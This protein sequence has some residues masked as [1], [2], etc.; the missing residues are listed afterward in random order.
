MTEGPR[1]RRPW[2]RSSPASVPQCWQ[3]ERVVLGRSKRCQ[4]AYAFRW[5]CSYIRLELA[6][7]GSAPLSPAY[8]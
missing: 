2:A 6:Q 5:E 4:L 1:L 7:P 8:L 3:R